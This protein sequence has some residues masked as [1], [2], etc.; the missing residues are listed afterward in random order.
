MLNFIN[1]VLMALFRRYSSRT[2]DYQKQSVSRVTIMVHRWVEDRGFCSPDADMATVANRMGIS[3]ER[4][5]TYCLN[6]LGK[7]FRTWRKELRIVESQRLMDEDP[8]ISI[9]QLADSVG[10]D[11]ANFRR[12]FCEVSGCSPQEWKEKH[13]C[14]K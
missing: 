14:N 5:S 10:I 1:K 8:T 6:V 2:K 13:L 7:S 11:R 9:A 4:L 12:Q 3:R